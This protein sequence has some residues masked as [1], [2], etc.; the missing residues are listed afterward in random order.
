MCRVLGSSRAEDELFTIPGSTNA[1]VELSHNEGTSETDWTSPSIGTGDTKTMRDHAARGYTAGVWHDDL[2]KEPMLITADKHHILAYDLECEYSG[3]STLTVESTILCACLVCTCGYKAVVSRSKTNQIDGCEIYIRHTNS[4]MAST[5]INLI[6]QHNPLFTIGHN[7]YDFDNVR[8]A[9]SLDLESPYRNYF[10]TTSSA[11]GKNVVNMGFIMCIPGI[12][13]FDT[14]RYMRKSMVQRFHSFAL[15]DLANTLGLTNRKLST[16]D[17]K[18]DLGWFSRS[19]FN[20]TSMVRY[21]M[22]DCEVNLDLCFQLDL[23]NQMMAICNITRSYMLDVMIYST[24]AIAASALC[25][26]ALRDD[27]KYV[28]TR[29]DYRPYEFEGGYVHF[30][31][32]IVCEM[33]MVFDFV[34]MYPSVMTAAHVSPESIDYLDLESSDDA[35]YH[36]KLSLASYSVRD[37]TACFGVT[38]YGARQVTTS[39]CMAVTLIAKYSNF[40][41]DSSLPGLN[42]AEQQRFCLLHCYNVVRAWNQADYTNN[43]AKEVCIDICSDRLFGHNTR[44]KLNVPI[45]TVMKSQCRAML[46]HSLT[47]LK[48][49]QTQHIQEASNQPHSVCYQNIWI[50]SKRQVA[51]CSVDWESSPLGAE[52]IVC[53]PES[54]CK[55]TLGTNVASSVCKNLMTRR[56]C[57]KGEIKLLGRSRGQ[58][59]DTETLDAEMKV[60]DLLQWALKIT[61]NSLYGCLA[62]REYN[63]YSPRC[64]M[65]VTAMGRWSVHV[66]LAVTQALGCIV[67]YGDTDSV[68]LVVPNRSVT[69]KTHRSPFLLPEYVQSLCSSESLSRR[70]A[71]ELLC[72]GGP[73]VSSL[74]RHHRPFKACIAKILNH[75][76]GFTPFVNLV[77]EAQETG[78]KTTDGEDTFVFHKM[79]VFASKHYVAKDASGG[80][81][82]KGVSYVRRTGARV[83]DVAAK[84]FIQ[85][86]LSTYSLQSVIAALRIEYSRFK[87]RILSGVYS[88]LYMVR[89]TKSGVT[90]DYVRI[91]G[92][93][94]RTLAAKYAEF[95]DLEQDDIDE[96]YYIDILDSCLRSIC[97]CIGLSDETLITRTV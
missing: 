86:A 74:N 70:D 6:K 13:N 4:T 18:F 55:F 79:A 77:I 3:D 14:L 40:T 89:A 35:R 67:M 41:T 48:V 83:Q 38:H 20:S 21:N 11:I 24:G 32:P 5:T 8:L 85:I 25:A 51:D 26:S 92:Q 52:V 28:W 54:V 75:I 37:D 63:T 93:G 50:P 43:R 29:C 16:K 46:Q 80:L 87:T 12:N 2:E 33:P 96:E 90:K 10:C 68:M 1:S 64:G 73:T 72:G 94:P 82:S 61:A 95:E 47:R 58:R 81:Y 59:E 57:V 31:K 39:G 76:M 84:K 9:C 42:M 30:K 91:I 78:S 69:H 65:C 34:S 22:M 17:M 44:S 88:E 60:K 66:A 45:T 7:I 53:L 56:K 19:G 49:H 27:M 97:V 62:F 15:G 71:L 23:I 36:V